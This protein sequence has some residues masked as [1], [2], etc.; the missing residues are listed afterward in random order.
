ML[1]FFLQCAVAVI[2]GYKEIKI[3]AC[4]FYLSII[5]L[6]FHAKNTSYVKIHGKLQRWGSDNYY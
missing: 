6:T 2:K 3:K 1:S 5:T 4:S